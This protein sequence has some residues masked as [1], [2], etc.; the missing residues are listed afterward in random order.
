MKS[1]IQALFLSCLLASLH[2]A[3]DEIYSIAN[4]GPSSID[5]PAHGIT[6]SEVLAKFGEPLTQKESI[7]SPP[8]IKWVYAEFTVYFESNT[9]IHSVNNK[10]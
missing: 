3:A 5:T 8:I 9:V 6:M 1:I 7:G 4:P 2:C 10:K